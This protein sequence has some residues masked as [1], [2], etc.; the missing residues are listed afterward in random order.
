MQILQKGSMRNTQV[1]FATVTKVHLAACG[2]R[3][4][5]EDLASSTIVADKV[6]QEHMR[7]AYYFQNHTDHLHALLALACSAKTSQTSIGTS[8]IPAADQRH[9]K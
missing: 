7:L 8:R 9:A 6:S 1:G 4:T 3:L 5:T 2:R